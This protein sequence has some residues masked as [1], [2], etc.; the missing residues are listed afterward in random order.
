MLSFLILP[1]ASLLLSSFACLPGACLPGDWPQFRGPNADAHVTSK[2]PLEW[3][4]SKNVEW[5][6]AIPGLGW[7]SPSISN[8]RIFLTT[9]VPQEEGLSLRAMALDQKSGK[10]IWDREIRALEKAP[11]IHTK[12]SHASPTPLVDGDS[13]YVHFGAQGMAKLKASDG[14]VEW[15]SEVLQ[16][17][18]L[19][20][21]GGSPVLCNG[22][23]LIACD[24]TQ[25]PF[26][27]AI[28]AATGKLAWKTLRSVEARLSH[29]FVTSTVAEVNGQALM[30]SPG[31]E[32]MAM[33]DV[34]TGR[35]VCRVRAPGW[36]VVPQP[37]VGHGMVFYNHDYDNPELMAVK[38]GG[39]GDV[40]DTHVVWRIQRGAPS[41]PSP[42]LIGDELYF[43]ADNGIASC[44]DAKT[45]ERHWMERLGGNFSASPVFVNGRILFLNEEGLATWVAPE[46]QFKELGKNQLPGRTFATPAFADNAMFLRTDEYLYKF[47]E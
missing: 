36:S 7:S 25:Q 30:I 46:K 8:G 12:N 47:S 37:A 11:A 5:K 44:V 42:L 26:V 21:N 2:S 6:V 43:V 40:T 32:H 33:Y 18:P 24:G 14:S 34:E 31:P 10:V 29:S 1:T 23:L 45:G 19:H 17:N 27:A 38:L 13:V 41:T 22:K 3:S 20:G 35:E 9:A 4:D 15:F 39:S 16:Y 28:D